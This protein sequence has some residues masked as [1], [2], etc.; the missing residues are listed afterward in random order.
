MASD[1]KKIRTWLGIVAVATVSVVAITEGFNGRVMMTSIVS[2]S[3]LGGA[4]Y[5]GIVDTIVGE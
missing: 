1:G 4:E 5:S 3:L 2:I